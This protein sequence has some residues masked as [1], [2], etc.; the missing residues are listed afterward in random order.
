MPGKKIIVTSGIAESG[1][2]Q[3]NLNFEFGQYI[4]DVCDEVIL[5]GRDQTRPVFDG[6]ENKKFNKKNIHIL[7][8]IKKTFALI[9]SLGE[10]EVYVLLENDLP[11]IFNEE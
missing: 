9:R 3:H 1:P 8:S 6:L 11:D 5:I 4:A 10:E 2:E 7:Q